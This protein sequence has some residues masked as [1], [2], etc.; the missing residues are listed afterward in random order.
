MW[1]LVTTNLRCQ[2]VWFKTELKQTNKGDLLGIGLQN[3]IVFGLFHKSQIELY[4]I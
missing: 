2:F 1:N 4:M 3:E